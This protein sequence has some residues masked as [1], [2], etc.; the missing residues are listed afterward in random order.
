MVFIPRC[1]KRTVLAEN[2]LIGKVQFQSG[3]SMAE[4]HM[5][6][7]SV[8]TKSTGLEYLEMSKEN[9]FLLTTCSVQVLVLVLTADLSSCK[10]WEL[11]LHAGRQGST[12]SSSVGSCTFVTLDV[13]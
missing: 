2:G 5:E 10:E 6:I 7:C 4:V 12:W 11:H 8:F 1:D 3:M 13:S 9:I